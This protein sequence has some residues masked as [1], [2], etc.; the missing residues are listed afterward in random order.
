MYNKSNAFN[1]QQLING[2]PESEL[3]R[4]AQY[5]MIVEVLTDACNRILSRLKEDPD[6]LEKATIELIEPLVKLD[7]N[8]I[9]DEPKYTC[10][11]KF[12]SVLGALTGYSE[13]QDNDIL[14]FMNSSHADKKMLKVLNRYIELGSLME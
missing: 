8:S 5:E 2:V 7:F 11:N 14:F 4:V 6:Q 12:I 1:S 10:I 9:S 3:I 13:F